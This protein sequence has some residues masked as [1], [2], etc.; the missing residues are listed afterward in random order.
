M[1]MFHDF[2]LI[3][4]MFQCF[5]SRSII[6]HN[7]PV[8]PTSYPSF[9][10]AMLDS[11]RVVVFKI[12]QDKQ[13]DKIQ[14]NLSEAFN[15]NIVNPATSENPLYWMFIIFY[16]EMGFTTVT[17]GFVVRTQYKDSM[18]NYIYIICIHVRIP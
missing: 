7:C 16:V 11:Q 13:L 8:C 15:A 6:F 14:S 10:R 17:R 3:F 12:K 18:I 5:P 4:M 1:V 2:P 9:S